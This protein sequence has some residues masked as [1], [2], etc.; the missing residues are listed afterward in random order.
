[1]VT[2]KVRDSGPQILVIREEEYI[3]RIQGLPPTSTQCIILEHDELND[4]IKVLQDYA[5]ENRNKRL[6]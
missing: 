5:N 4:L 2:F 3:P 6:Q 1:M